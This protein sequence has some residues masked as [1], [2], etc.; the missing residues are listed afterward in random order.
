MTRIVKAP[1]VTSLIFITLFLVINL[2]F[3]PYSVLGT[4]KFEPGPQ[5]NERFTKYKKMKHSNER[6]DYLIMGSSIAGTFSPSFIKAEYD[7]KSYN[8]SVLGGR[9]SDL[10]LLA[11]PI[12]GGDTTVL[13]GIDHTMF[14]LP[15]HEDGLPYRHHPDATHQSYFSFY[16]DYLI[17]PGIITSIKKIALQNSRR[18][19]NYDLLDGHYSLPGYENKIND[20][21]HQFIKKNILERYSDSTP[22][23]LSV[24]SSEIEQLVHLNQLLSLKGI[25]VIPFFQPIHE[26]EKEYI[27]QEAY[28]QFKQAVS[29][30][31]NNIID[32]SNCGST[33]STIWYDTRHFRSIL[34]NAVISQLITGN[35][36]QG[37]I[38]AS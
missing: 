23:V 34:S 15:P 10:V 36:C 11:V 4:S 38:N 6:Y 26:I 24:A 16:L 5:L 7:K 30:V 19:I 8:L 27:G 3:D 31:F 32:L 20:N 25:K 14:L 13:L 1:I 33:N 17:S 18:T 9:P 28:E 21:H 37:Y 12:Q 35:D 22:K 29:G 2:T